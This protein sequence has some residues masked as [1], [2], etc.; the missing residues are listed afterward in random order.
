MRATG[1]YR[2]FKKFGENRKVLYWVLRGLRVGFNIDNVAR[3]MLGKILLN[4][5][6]GTG[7]APL[8]VWKPGIG[9]QKT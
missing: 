2:S 1:S 3:R 8:R 6:P 5:G 4:G 7:Q 9:P